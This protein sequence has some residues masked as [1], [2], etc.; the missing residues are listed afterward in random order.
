[1]EITQERDNGDLDQVSSKQL[2]RLK[3]CL[4]SGYTL[5]EPT[6]FDHQLVVQ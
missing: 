2:K 5:K 6:G 3:N 1:M 4:D